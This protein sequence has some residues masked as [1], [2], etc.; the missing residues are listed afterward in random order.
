MSAKRR[1]ALGAALLA[2]AAC[3]DVPVP[4]A[5]D[6]VPAVQPGQDGGPVPVPMDAER[7]TPPSPFD[8]GAARD[9][10]AD[11][12]V[13]AADAAPPPPDAEPPYPRCAVGAAPVLALGQ[14]LRIEACPLLPTPRFDHRLTVLTSG[15][16]LLAGGFGHEGFDRDAWLFDGIDWGAVQRIADDRHRHTLTAVPGDR[17]FLVGGD[18]NTAEP[19][20]EPQN[21]AYAFRAPQ[22]PGDD[23]GGW[24]EDHQYSHRRAL[25]AAVWTGERLVV[26]GGLDAQPDREGSY[27]GTEI[28]YPDDG[29]RDPAAD[30]PPV[31]A[32]HLAH[33]VDGTLLFGGYAFDEDVPGMRRANDAV[34]RLDGERWTRVHEGVVHVDGPAVSTP[35]GVLLVGGDPAGPAGRL[36]RLTADGVDWRGEMS[37]ERVGA[38]AARVG[39]DSLVAVLGGQGVQREL[40]V[41]LVDVA[42]ARHIVLRLEEPLIGDWRDMRA[43]TLPDGDALFVGGLINGLATDRCL[44]LSLE[45]P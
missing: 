14:C 1:W 19:L 39:A 7:D 30:T 36:R 29:W 16:V 37:V 22:G 26:A 2:C 42:A 40:I 34:H 45:A 10:A 21:E 38:A 44:R 6:A 5:R 25:H 41:D 35:G 32:P 12:G 8:V 31:F 33:G 27:V 4:E 20:D 28:W 11:R 9:A 13:P 24:D 17:A 23:D 3:I 43:T 15:R 18:S